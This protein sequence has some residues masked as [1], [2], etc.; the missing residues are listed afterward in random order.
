MEN[1][2]KFSQSGGKAL[3]YSVFNIERQNQR[4]L[5]K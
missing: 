3:L 2:K 4:S 5:E 1:I